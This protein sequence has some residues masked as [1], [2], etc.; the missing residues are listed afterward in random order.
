MLTQEFIQARQQQLLDLKNKLEAEL[1][2]LHPHTE[3]GEGE[4]D[5]A[6]EFEVDEVSQDL[7]ARIKSDLALV[8]KALVKIANGT[9]GFDDDGKEI[10]PE[11]LE[12]M[13]HANKA[14]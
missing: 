8:E 9:Y 3:T 5:A 7:I 1:K 11:R 6:F 10:D 2:E 14:L 12:I 13:P 4:G